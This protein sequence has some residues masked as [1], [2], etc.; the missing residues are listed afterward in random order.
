MKTCSKQYET[1]CPR[2][3]GSMKLNLLGWDKLYLNHFAN[4]NTKLSKV[5]ENLL[6]NC[7]LQVCRVV[8][9]THW[10]KA[11]YEDLY[12]RLNRSKLLA[13]FVCSILTFPYSDSLVFMC[14]VFLKKFKTR[15]KTC[16]LR[17][18]HFEKKKVTPKTFQSCFFFTRFLH[19]A[20]NE[21]L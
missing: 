12:L 18:L 4:A 17:L 7:S 10:N 1:K 14:W 8:E 2:T 20:N 6:V 13:I 5:Q 9:C 16:C 11:D 3:K 21:T 15:L 19:A